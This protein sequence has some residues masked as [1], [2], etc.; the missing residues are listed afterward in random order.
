MR[1]VV[2]AGG[3]GLRLKPLTD[4][5]NKHL[6]PVYDR[7]MIHYPLDTLRLFGIEDV[8]IVTGG[9]YVGAF[10]EYLGDG[11]ALGMNLSYKVQKESRG[12]ADALSYAREFAQ[13]DP[14]LTI[15]GDNIFS[16]TIAEI[17]LPEKNEHACIWVKRVPKAERFG[18]LT[19]GKQSHIV[20]KPRSAPNGLAVTGLYLYP[21]DV[22]SFIETLVPS[23]RGELE[24]TDVNNHFLSKG[25]CKINVL[26][27]DTFWSDAGTFDSLHDASH[28]VRERG[29]ER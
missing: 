15:L 12:I 4:I 6:L 1:G 8:L 26:T 5:T 10:S 20:E 23:G 18:V 19:E 29:G 28:W 3:N 14:V 24:I 17:S 13:N 25:R 9:K 27:E 7:P 21:S 11:S 2:L 16:E 22:F